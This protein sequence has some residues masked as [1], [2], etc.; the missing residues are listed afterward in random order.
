MKNIVLIENKK[1]TKETKVKVQ[2]TPACY[3]NIVT[4]RIG[5]RSSAFRPKP[6]K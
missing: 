2:A 1:T 3:Q 6:N 4:M 5:A